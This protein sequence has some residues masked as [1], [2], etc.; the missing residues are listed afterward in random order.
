[1]RGRE[2]IGSMNEKIESFEKELRTERANFPMFRGSK[3]EA[4]IELKELELA[5]ENLGE[6]IIEK[7][8]ISIERYENTFEEFQDMDRVQIEERA[9]E[10]KDKDRFSW[11][12]KP[13]GPR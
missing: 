9:T 7:Y 13:L 12:G 2:V 10:L 5:L 11:R 8:A 3:G 4:S 6:R 1:M